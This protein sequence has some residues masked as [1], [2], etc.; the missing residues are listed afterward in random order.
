MTMRFAFAFVAAMAV[1]GAASAA[2]QVPPTVAEVSRYAG[3]HAAAHSGNLN[4][5]PISLFNTF[6]MGALLGFAFLRSGDLWLPIG[7]HFGW[8]WT[9]PLFGV[10]LSGFTMGMTGYAMHWNVP[11]LWSGGEYGPEAGLVT[12]MVVPVLGYALWRA[13]VRKQ[14]SFLLRGMDDDGEMREV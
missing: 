9:L 14:K 5:S 13:P 2:A 1:L 4:A 7:L 8:N 10:N 11:A 3:L 6:A 12:S